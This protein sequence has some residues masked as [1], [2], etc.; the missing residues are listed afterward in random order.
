MAEQ[1]DTRLG[2]VL[3]PEEYQSRFVDFYQPYS[4]QVQSAPEVNEPEDEDVEPVRPDILTPVGM[5]D[6]SAPNIF[7]QIPLR[8]TGQQF[9][10]YDA[11]DYINDFDTQEQ[12]NLSDKS[13]KRYLEQAGGIPTAVATIATGSPIAGFAYGAA[14][15]ANKQHRKNAVAIQEQ[16]GSA[17]DIFKFNGQTVSRA[18]GSKIFTG[19][20]GGLNQADMFRSREIERGFI[21]GT[22]SFKAGVGS[23][24]AAR[25]GRAGPEVGLEGVTRIQGVI[26]DA[27]GTAHSGQRNESGH[28]MV[29]ASQAQALREREFMQAASSAGMTNIARQ[30]ANA[31]YDPT[32]IAVEFKQMVDGNMRGQSYH[33]G[34]FHKTSNLSASQNA[35]ALADRAGFAQSAIEAIRD[36]Y[37]LDPATKP[38][39]DDGAPPP[40]APDPTIVGGDAPTP[41]PPPSGV[42]GDDPYDN[43]DGGSPS[44]RGLDQRAAARSSFERM[45]DIGGRE[46]GR[47]PVGSSGFRSVTT[48]SGRQD[49]YTGGAFGGSPFGGFADGGRVGMQA[50]G[51][52]QRPLPEAGFVA[53]PPENFTERETVADDQNGSVAEGTFVINA[54][55]VEYAGSDDIRKMILDAYSKAREKGLDIG[56]VDRKLYEGT[57]DVALSKGEVL[58]PPELAK[59]IGYDRLEKINNRGKKEVT[60]RQEAAGGGFLDGK[61]F[62]DGGEVDYEDRI[63][64]DEVRRKMKALV[65]SLPDD[66][67]VESVYYQ[68][69]YPAAQRYEDEEARLNETLPSRGR[70]FS[71]SQR[72]A[73][74]T[75][76]RKRSTDP[77]INVPMTP[78]LYNLAILAEEVAHQDALKYRQEY[79]PKKHKVG[80]RTFEKEQDYLEELRA[81]DFALS[82]V[83][84]L[85]PK[86]DKTARGARASYEK[87][88]AEH[89]ALTDNRELVAA[90][91]K[92]YPELNRFIKEVSYPESKVGSK[93]LPAGSFL[94]ITDDNYYGQG[95]PKVNPDLNFL[96]AATREDITAQNEYHAS[97]DYMF[98]KFKYLV[99]QLFVDAERPEY[100][101]GYTASLPK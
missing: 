90:Y 49:V 57:V 78:T 47:G 54:A 24:D 29:S 70:F 82:V 30:L 4:I 101:Q 44:V 96:Q 99:A 15:L 23:L 35:Q 68:P 93:T 37:G 80:R 46:P 62:A 5:R 75:G 48:P 98:D 38:D 91:V 1:D 66:V 73:P 51:A 39:S 7:G 25:S 86:G 34:F 16:G 100:M 18:P 11:V 85:F 87:D 53:G 28:M 58:V 20:L 10:R 97:F 41:P 42:S 61:K 21:P 76:K 50:G 88:F 94:T 56:R 89:L 12:T 36:K 33:G 2:N 95:Q 45:T 6:E 69:G 9:S 19:N 32:L 17:G 72:I 92:K 26:M 65:A 14:S 27:F 71:R 59:I 8:G 52:A 74:A 22:M 55:A 77:K 31:G 81:K 79:D 84:G 43:D 40:R 67:E 60:R 64:T 3:T 63:V 13:F 83:G